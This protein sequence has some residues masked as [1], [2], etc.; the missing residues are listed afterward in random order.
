M[1]SSE[2]AAQ[3][4]ATRSPPS[5]GRSV[6]RRA[7]PRSSA[8]IWDRLANSFSLDN[9]PSYMLS[10]HLSR[11]F[12]PYELNPFD[13]NPLRHLVAQTVDFERVNRCSGL[14]VFVTATNVRTGRARIFTQ[15][16]LSVTR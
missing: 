3:A 10:E 8:T 1:G 4:H 6:T 7:G 9:A 14:K 12:S 11:T 13:I 16:E 5:G 2:P 15:P